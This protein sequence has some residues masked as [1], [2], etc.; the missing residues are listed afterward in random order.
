MAFDN[1]GFFAAEMCTWIIEHRA[2]QR[3]WFDL[4]ERFS[5]HCHDVAA[6]LQINRSSNQQLLCAALFIRHLEYFQAAIL[7]IERGMGNAASI[8]LRAQLETLFSLTMI[9]KSEQHTETFISTDAHTRLSNMKKMKRAVEL[10]LSIYTAEQIARL[11]A[12]ISECTEEL[13]KSRVPKAQVEW[14]AKQADMEPSYLITYAHL[15][16]AVHSLSRNVDSYLSHDES[17]NLSHLQW[18]PA[19]GDSAKHLSTAVE[20]LSFALHAIERVFRLQTNEHDLL[21]TELTELLH[22]DDPA[23]QTRR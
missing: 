11:D 5:R 3:V 15:S 23:N 19:E 2:A 14:L 7:M 1:D 18:G 21:H 8:A 6:R 13:A 4:A 17:G 12:G 20:N 10:G 9:S 22:A 16:G